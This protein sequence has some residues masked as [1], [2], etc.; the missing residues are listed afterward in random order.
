M[1]QESTESASCPLCG[2]THEARCKKC[3]LWWTGAPTET[4][5]GTDAAPRTNSKPIRLRSEA[6]LRYVATLLAF[7]GFALGSASVCGLSLIQTPPTSLLAWLA[8]LAGL[9]LGVLVGTY[10][11][12]ALAQLA[13]HAVVPSQ[14]SREGA[15]IRV[16]VWHTWDGLWR[17]FRRTDARVPRAQL[18]GVE[19][20]VGQGGETHV[21]LA[22]D[23]G[24]SFGTGWRGSRKAALRLGEELSAWVAARDST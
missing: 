5:A 11:A 10:F 18:C 2:P 7:G 14:L 13:L 21:L 16:R 15:Q 20:M 23:S 24:Q 17:G 3:G 19:F 9:S 22:H 1:E 12:G 8:V 4:F 6:L